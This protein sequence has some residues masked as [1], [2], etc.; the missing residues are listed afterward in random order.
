MKRLHT[1]EQ[2]LE[3]IE[4]LQKE[5]PDIW[6]SSDMIVGYPGET[7]EDF[8]ETLKIVDTVKYY[9]EKIYFQ[10]MISIIV[11][12]NTLKKRIY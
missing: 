6:F 3:V 4:A 10:K 12:A 8:Q 1:I 9:L 7:E 5:R 2:Y 11:L